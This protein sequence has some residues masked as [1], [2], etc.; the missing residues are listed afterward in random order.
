VILIVTVGVLETSEA[1]GEFRQPHNVCM[2]NYITEIAGFMSEHRSSAFMH[3][4]VPTRTVQNW[5][6]HIDAVSYMVT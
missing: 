3:K 1:K 6:N 4:C 5:N 2:L